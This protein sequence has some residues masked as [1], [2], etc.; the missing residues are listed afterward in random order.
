MDAGVFATFFSYDRNNKKTKE[1]SANLYLVL[2][3]IYHK[4]TGVTEQAD[5]SFW[6]LEPTY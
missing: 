5:G 1:W 6:V 3:N 2:K 4:I